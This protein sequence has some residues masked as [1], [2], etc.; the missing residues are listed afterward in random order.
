[1][2]ILDGDRTNGIYISDNIRLTVVSAG[3]GDVRLRIDGPHGV[4]IRKLNTPDRCGITP[5]SSDL[6]DNHDD[7]KWRKHRR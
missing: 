3:K 6:N 5:S 2:R 1:M 7:N 4:T